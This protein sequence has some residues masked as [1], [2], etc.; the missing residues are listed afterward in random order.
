MRT[1]APDRWWPLT[2]SDGLTPGSRGGHGP[3]RYTVT[4]SEPHTVTFALAEKLPFT[5][6]HRFEIEP[7]GETGPA[8]NP[9]SATVRWRH[10]L[11]VTDTALT[12]TL[13]VPLH[14]ALIE[15]LL[16]TAAA[17]GSSQID[18][19]QYPSRQPLRRTDRL[20]RAAVA[21]I[22]RRSWSTSR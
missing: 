10:T 13:V 11:V 7:T 21:L 5:G 8:A 9:D 17:I 3:V 20:R 16:D 1:V 18:P 14:D 6:W 2:L 15:D 19:G 4:A 12:R 22:D